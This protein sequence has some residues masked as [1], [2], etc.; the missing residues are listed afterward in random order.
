MPECLLVLNLDSH[1]VAQIKEIKKEFEA[2]FPNLGRKAKV[3]EATAHVTL[4]NFPGKRNDLETIGQAIQ[5]VFEAESQFT[6]E[7]NQV[8]RY[9][10]MLYIQVQ[11]SATL[12]H[13]LEKLM[14]SIKKK[15][16]FLKPHITIARYVEDEVLEKAFTYFKA[17]NI[18]IKADA[19]GVRL[20][21][22]PHGGNPETLYKFN[23]LKLED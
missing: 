23:F 12:Q 17:Q 1:A 2:Q 11:P 6:L 4:A 14:L 18:A 20:V 3:L 22:K 9:S 5:K 13:I 19:L 7:L 21:Y 8:D 10:K 15:Y 16:L